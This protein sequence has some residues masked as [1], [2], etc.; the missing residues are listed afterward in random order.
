MGLPV[1]MR[2]GV[3]KAYAALG[4]EHAEAVKKAAPKR[5]RRRR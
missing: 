1:N 2:D 3:E 5:R 4:E